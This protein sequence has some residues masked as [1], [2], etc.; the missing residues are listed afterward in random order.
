MSKADSSAISNA[1]FSRLPRLMHQGKS[2][3]ETR[4]QSTQ[5]SD[6]GFIKH[7]LEKDCGF[8]IGD[9]KTAN[10][11][12]KKEQNSSL[13]AEHQALKNDFEA[14]KMKIA[15]D[16]QSYEQRIKELEEHQRESL[17]KTETVNWSQIEKKDLR[18]FDLRNEISG[19]KNS[20]GELATEIHKL[21]L[22]KQ[23]MKA[24]YKSVI[25]AM[26]KNYQAEKKQHEDEVQE[27]KEVLEA[28]EDLITKQGIQIKTLQE[29]LQQMNDESKVLKESNKFAMEEHQKLITNAEAKYSKLFN[30]LGERKKSKLTTCVALT[31]E[32][33]E[34]GKQKAI[35]EKE[36]S[37]LN[38]ELLCCNES[39]EKEKQ[40]TIKANDRNDSYHDK[41]QEQDE[42][43]RKL[44]E[45]L[46]RRKGIKR[47]LPFLR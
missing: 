36:K 16:K 21:E 25:D 43:I 5:V 15:N 44:Q 30:D 1:I 2:S 32:K 9:E 23:S 34:L 20:N 37:D 3:H 22:D 46:G 39:W 6:L 41:V 18:I 47:F 40:N 29:E 10:E 33:E 19:L 13:M 35:L 26:D 28:G 31:S 27:L 42:E 8:E 17:D 4:L 14:I 11:A 7:V 45:K 12:D 24:S 38:E